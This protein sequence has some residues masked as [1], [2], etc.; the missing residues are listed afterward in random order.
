MALPPQI[1][2]N[3]TDQTT[4]STI[5]INGYQY[6][7][8]LILYNGNIALR[9]PNQSIHTLSITDNFY[10]IFH[11]GYL[12]IKNEF[13]LLGNYTTVNTPAEVDS[14]LNTSYNFN[15]NIGG[16]IL[17]V[18]IKPMRPP[19]NTDT[20]DDANWAL[21]F[22]FSIYD[23]DELSDPTTT[24]KLKILKFRDIREDI[25][26]NDHTPWS[27]CNIAAQSNFNVSQE[28]DS[29]RSIKTGVA[30][31]D[32]INT[33]FSNFTN[34][35]DQN[36]DTGNT[37][38]FYSTPYN[39][40]RYDTLE[41][42]L[43][44]HISLNDE[45]NCFL[46][47]ERNQTWTLLPVEFYFQNALD[48]KNKLP[49]SFNIDIFNTNNQQYAQDLESNV[50][51]PLQ[52]KNP[53]DLRVSFDDF[54]GLFNY[55]FNNIANYDSCEDL[56]TTPVC[57]YNFGKKTFAIDLT[58]NNITSIQREF[59]SMYIDKMYGKSP[60]NTIPMNEFKTKNRV[61]NA[62][63]SPQQSI[64]QRKKEGRNRVLEKA[65]AFSHGINFNLEGMTIRRAGRFISIL[66][67][68][69][70]PE[71]AFQ[72]TLQGEWLITQVVHVFTGNV[73]RHDVTAVKPY[74][75]TKLT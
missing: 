31:K 42:L 13:D 17:V 75:F 69:S 39:E 58:E 68:G 5:V 64:S 15:S 72:N 26:E 51:I 6:L 52:T 30:I 22:M 62:L 4:N 65:L 24:Q 20:L 38:V 33:T 36:W 46:R 66:N 48:K 41:Y 43:D 37:L 8:D 7:F 32:I 55:S 3:P 21:S 29:N 34:T 2:N 54:T 53:Y 40:S 67:T 11:S 49:G 59:Q 27:T 18:K 47:F 10:S 73:Y 16:D 9:I 19:N 50:K 14:L 44:Q 60:T 28:S 45:D 74:T 61:F 25:L 71:T 70:Y 56:V 1:N 35:F 63:F 57:G 12:A 23:E